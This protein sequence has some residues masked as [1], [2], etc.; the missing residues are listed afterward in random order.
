M[1]ARGRA[2]VGA[3]LLAVI[4]GAGARGGAED[5]SG[6]AAQAPATGTRAGAAGV[7]AGTPAG[8]L[9]RWVAEVR[10]GLAREVRPRIATSPSQAL[11]RAIALYVSH[12]E[13]IEQYYERGRPLYAGHA[14]ATEVKRSE[15]RFHELMQVLQR[16]PPGPAAADSALTRLDAQYARMLAVA[17]ASGAQLSPWPAGSSAGSSAR[18]GDG[19]AS[20]ASTPAGRRHHTPSRAPSGAMAP[21][22]ATLDSAG[23]AYARGDAAGALAGVERAYLEHF[24]PLEPRLPSARVLSI[25]RLIHLRLRPELA[26]GAPTARVQASFVALRAALLEADE[27]LSAPEPSWVGALNAFTIVLREGLEA[28]LLIGAMLAYLTATG[29]PAAVKRQIHVG[30][31]AGVVATLA[32]WSAA[33]TLLPMDGARRELVE[34][35]TSLLAVGVLLYVSNWLFQKTYMR[36]WK[37]YLRERVGAAAAAGSSLAMATLAF[38]AVFREGFETVLFYQALSFD[39][40]ARAVLAG[41]VPGLLA[42]LALAYGIIRLGLRLPLRAV[43]AATNA[44][45]LYLAF[46]F[47]GKGVY[48]LQEAGVF[49]AHPLGWLPHLGAPA[50]LLGLYPVA[51]T[52]AAQA[53]LLLLLALTYVWSFSARRGRLSIGG[54]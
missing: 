50:R 46:V 35:V 42:I 44:V 21:L 2:A 12:Q 49:T 13:Y 8:G 43:F 19:P 48:S 14:L 30:A 23:G 6:A 34:G 4:L 24:E 11:E 7:L 9:A 5:A 3:A 40:G 15:T 47:V 32:L 36:D 27:R 22:L 41:F 37:D 17:R 28:V 25:E 20:A 10:A 52:L 26:Q 33:G 45:L 18:G 53:A 31:V 39:V 1:G 29:A 38:A 51:E 54:P 16:Q